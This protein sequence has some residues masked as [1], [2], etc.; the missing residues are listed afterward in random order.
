MW[1]PTLVSAGTGYPLNTPQFLEMRVIPINRSQKIPI[2]IKNLLKVSAVIIL[3][4]A[5][6]QVKLNQ[7]IIICSKIVILRAVVPRNSIPLVLVNFKIIQIVIII[8]MFFK[9]LT[10]FLTKIISIRIPLLHKIN[11]LAVNS[12]EVPLVT[13]QVV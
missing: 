9:M 11:L 8:K 3:T 7:I 10:N 1:F 5:N 4:T 6:P 12:L 2:I 13:P